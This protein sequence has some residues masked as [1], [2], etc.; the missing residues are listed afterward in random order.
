MDLISRKFTSSLL[1][2]NRISVLSSLAH[3]VQEKLR[4][5]FK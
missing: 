2:V 4:T 3:L 1:G 5:G